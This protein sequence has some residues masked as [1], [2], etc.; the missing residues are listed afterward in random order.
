MR[1]G[2]GE[3]G[4]EEEHVYLQSHVLQSPVIKL[5]IAQKIFFNYKK[6]HCGG[7][8]MN[9]SLGQSK[10]VTNTTCYHE[11][12]KRMSTVKSVVITF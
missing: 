3:G 8:L 12:H 6:S 2:G 9:G 5:V 10:R 7:T 4:T 11:V 1:E